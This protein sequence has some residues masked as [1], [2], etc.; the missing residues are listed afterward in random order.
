VFQK[1]FEKIKIQTLLWRDRNVRKAIAVLVMLVVALLCGSVEEARAAWT[2]VSSIRIF[3]LTKEDGTPLNP[4]DIVQIQPTGILRLRLIPQEYYTNLVSGDFRATVGITSESTEQGGV[5]LFYNPPPMGSDIGVVEITASS[6]TVDQIISIQLTTTITPLEGEEIEHRTS[7]FYLRLQ[8]NLAFD[9]NYVF[10]PK[11]IT[12]RDERGRKVSSIYMEAT[13][14]RELYVEA[15]DYLN[16]GYGDNDYT[17][18]PVVS[19]TLNMAPTV[20]SESEAD[21]MGTS[22]IPTLVGLTPTLPNMEIPPRTIAR[23]RITARNPGGDDSSNYEPVYTDFVYQISFAGM[24]TGGVSLANFL[25]NG[26]VIQ[27]P[28]VSVVIVAKDD[29]TGSFDDAGGTCNLLGLGA[30][31]LLVPVAL[32]RRKR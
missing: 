9:F 11:S 19:S 18:H 25:P 7:V 14:T 22:T 26:G 16:D 27:T 15:D 21:L 13:Q 4:G 5:Q 17:M 30:L 1:R 8:S 28:P 6:A 12:L 3:S 24:T 23:V 32:I 2:Q 31:I 10:V 20:Q 29:A